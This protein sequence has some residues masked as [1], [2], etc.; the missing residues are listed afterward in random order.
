M[1]RPLS[2]DELT[3]LLMVMRMNPGASLGIL[4]RAIGASR[5]KVLGRIHCLA[6]L[7]EAAKRADGR[8]R[9]LT[10]EPKPELRQLPGSDPGDG[11]SAFPRWIRSVNSYLR[12]AT[13]EFDCV[14]YG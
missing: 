8:W 4:S 11:G 9:P 2:H 6:R 3:P 7:G 13:S 1:P 5:S 10:A 14:R 12:Q